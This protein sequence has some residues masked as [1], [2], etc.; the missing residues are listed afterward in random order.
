MEGPAPLL[1]GDLAVMEREMER[2]RK[3][4]EGGR[5]GEW[6]RGWKGESTKEKRRQNEEIEKE[7]GRRQETEKLSRFITPSLPS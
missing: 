2:E 5:E 3:K 6:M 7:R 4:G 1:L